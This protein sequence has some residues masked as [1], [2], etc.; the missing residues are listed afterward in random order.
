MSLART[1]GFALLVAVAVVGCGSSSLAA[2]VPI[3][4]DADEA[5]V[6]LRGTIEAIHF[7]NIN[8]AQGRYTY[9]VELVVA[10]AGMAESTHAKD[11]DPGTFRV[12]VHKV[13]WSEL[14]ADAKARVAPEGPQ[15]EMNVD[16]WQAYT[17]GDAVELEVVA[18]GPGL[19]APV[20][21]AAS[22]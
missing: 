8:K 18:W 5:A 17:V 22:S 10:H 1:I 16:A 2:V 14:D 15:H 12:R 20:R 11:N 9:N 6:P 19:G 3:L 4:G 13:Y 7:Q 21:R